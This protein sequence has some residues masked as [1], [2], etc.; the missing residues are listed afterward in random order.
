MN[1]CLEI[2]ILCFL[3][4]NINICYSWTSNTAGGMA[5]VTYAGSTVY[6]VN[7]MCP[8]K[9]NQGYA[10]DGRNS[11]DKYLNPSTLSSFCSSHS[12][13]TYGFGHGVTASQK[14]GQCARIRVPRKDGG[15]NYMEVSMVDHFTS[16]MEV[17]TVE[18]EYLLAGTKWVK[19]DRADF[20]FSQPYNC[21]MLV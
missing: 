21:G 5:G 20:E 8:N 15:Y 6:N 9:A 12:G 17:G 10:C 18:I 4:I 7:T 2:I 13:T 3:S 1:F 14:C 11:G 16:S 19:G